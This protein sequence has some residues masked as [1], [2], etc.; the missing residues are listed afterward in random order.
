M[1]LAGSFRSGGAALV[2]L[3]LAC[4]S[5]AEHAVARDTVVG[6]PAIPA[7]APPATVVPPAREAEPTLGHGTY[8]VTQV[9]HDTLPYSEGT[10][11]EGDTSCVMTTYA[12]TLE[13]MG[14]RWRERRDY[15]SACDPK[16][17]NPPHK[18]TERT[19]KLR[20]KGD[21]LVLTEQ[22]KYYRAWDV[23]QR[24]DSLQDLVFTQKIVRVP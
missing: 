16:P 18:I 13:L 8:R 5:N 14:D 23:V 21:T 4:T 15:T 17:P 7:A 19:G 1:T 24:G 9:Q 3:A 20:L 6:A 11:P 12:I 22:T 2:A 10:G